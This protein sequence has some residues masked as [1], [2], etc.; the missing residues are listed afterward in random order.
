ML[1][2]TFKCIRL[3]DSQC[4]KKESSSKF[5]IEALRRH[6]HITL[7][8][9]R[10]SLKLFIND[11]HFLQITVVRHLRGKPPGVAK[12]LKQRLEGKLNLF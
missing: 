2:P 5:Y 12:S 6:L 9:D 1:D 3:T 10:V 11:K 4:K 8:K 7:L